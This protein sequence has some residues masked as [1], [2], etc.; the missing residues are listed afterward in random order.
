[1]AQRFMGR[2]LVAVALACPV[3]CSG[4]PSPAASEAGVPGDPALVRIET[5]DLRGEAT[6]G[7]R[8]FLNIPYAAPPIGELRWRA[9][10]PAAVWNGERDATGR[11]PSCPQP[12]LLGAPPSGVEDCLYLNVYTPPDAAAGADLP[13]MVWVHGGGFTLG[14]GADYDSR[15]LAPMAD[16]VVVTINYRLGALGFLALP[17]LKAEGPGLNHGLQDQQAA[18]RWVQRNIGRFG[19]DKARITLF[20]ESA[21]GI[22]TCLNMVSPTAEGLFHRAV[23]QSGTCSIPLFDTRI[24]TAYRKGHQAAA[25]VGCADGPERLA[26]LRAKPYSELVDAIPIGGVV[27]SL[28]G[29]WGPVVDG[30]LLP[31]DPMKLVK[32]G[33]LAEVPVIGGVNREEGNFVTAL[34]FDG[35]L[36][37]PPTEAEYRAAV[38]EL[39]GPTAGRTVPAV[40]ASARYGSPGQALSAVYT[41]A[42]FSCHTDRFIRAATRHTPTYA[43]QFNDPQAPSPLPIPGLRLG[44]AH[45]AEI[46]YLFNPH[47]DRFD[48]GQ[49]ALAHQMIQYWARFAATGRPDDP[50]LPAWSRYRKAATSYRELQPGGLPGTSSRSAFRFQHHCALWDRLENLP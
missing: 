18:L 9:P 43:Y 45:A 6:Q 50:G 13:V 27:E 21:G 20:G 48:G 7:H 40:Y 46:P 14:N 1:M 32:A 29:L 26:C 2:L 28:T 34:M 22:S 11:A 33:R 5:G 10:R 30:V 23:M 8:Q 4:A 12:G 41:D 38:I 25:K 17:E 31:D 19:G 42:L 35:T 44:A 16:A 15:A 36:G 3:V 49:R 47:W 39:F 37:R 24:D